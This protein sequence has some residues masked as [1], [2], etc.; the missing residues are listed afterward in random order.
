MKILLVE[1][2]FDVAQNVC[3][4]FEADGHAV[5]WAPDGP[6][7]LESAT[8]GGHDVIVLDIALPR[9]SGLELCRRLRDL[10]FAAVPI[11][12]LTARSDLPDKLAAFRYGADDYVVKPFELEELGGRLEALVRRAGGAVRDACLR[13]ADLEFDTAT[14]KVRRAGRLLP[15]TA[16]GR[17]ILEALMR[18][19]HRVVSRREIEHLV[20]G[21]DP[22]QTDSL[23]IHVHTLREAVDKPFGVRLI[24]TVRGAGYRLCIDEDA[25]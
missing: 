2:D 6:I 11:L 9:L 3:D 23:K 7:G 24:H 22:P 8:R 25:S 18:N 10:G 21:D 1:D 5:E 12:M 20:W 4:F 16:T 17:K 15:L 13:V 14:H 19:S